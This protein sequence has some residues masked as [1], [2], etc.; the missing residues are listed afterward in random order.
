VLQGGVN[1]AEFR[2]FQVNYTQPDSAV[3]VAYVHYQP[4]FYG[5]G[6]SYVRIHHVNTNLAWVS[7]DFRSNGSGLHWSDSYISGYDTALKVAGNGDT[8]RLTNVV[9]FAGY[10]ATANQGT[11]YTSNAIGFS[12]VGSFLMVYGCLS[13]GK[14]GWV[15]DGN[16]GGEF[17][18]F[19]NCGFDTSNGLS[20][21]NFALVHIVNSYFTPGLL[22]TFWINSADCNVLVENCYFS[23]NGSSATPLITATNGNVFIRNSIFN[24]A[25]MDVPLVN[26]TGSGNFAF[27]DNTLGGI[28]QTFTRSRLTIGNGIVSTIQGNI[29][30]A[31]FGAHTG[32]FVTFTG[33]NSGPSVM[34]GNNL[35][36]GNGTNAWAIAGASLLISGVIKDNIGYNPVGLSAITVGASPFTYTA[37]STSETVYISGGT[38]SLV[39]RGATTVASASPS[40]VELPPFGT[41]QVTYS[42]LPTMVKDIH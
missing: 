9:T 23:P 22:S 18:Q 19:A 42:V 41:V 31:L 27:T 7:G 4:T 26:H 29:L 28:D 6:A 5:V 14:T 24:L 39:K 25:G 1:R 17:S 10:G 32:T 36:G 12:A 2:E 11:V 40:T 21:S 30:S 33:G 20:L 38:V 3:L 8:Y 35:I 34:T 13:L 16:G 37:G 15:I